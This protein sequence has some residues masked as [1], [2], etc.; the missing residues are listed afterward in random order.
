MLSCA[1]LG[2]FSENAVR[3][4]TRRSDCK[5]HRNRMKSGCCGSAVEVFL[6]AFDCSCHML[7]LVVCCTSLC[8]MAT[9]HAPAFASTHLFLAPVKRFNDDLLPSHCGC[10]NLHPTTSQKVSRPWR[11][12]IQNLARQTRRRRS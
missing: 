8:R 2:T 5:R 9:R 10:Q 11:N 6:V 12:P 3:V 7:L 4:Q 1:G